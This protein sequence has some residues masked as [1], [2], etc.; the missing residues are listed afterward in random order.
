MRSAIGVTGQFSAVDGLLT[1]TENLRLMAD[2]YHLGRTEGRR[3][4]AELLD[5]FDL[6]AA[7]GKPTATYSRGDETQTRYRHD[8]DRRPGRGLPR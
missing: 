6:S 5:R 3:R 1:G 7:A 4:A 2:L 8:L